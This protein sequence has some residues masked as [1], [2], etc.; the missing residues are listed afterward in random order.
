L[1][2]KKFDELS[3]KI[4][5]ANMDPGV[6]RVNLFPH[7]LIAL[8]KVPEK[9]KKLWFN[10]RA[11]FLERFGKCTIENQALM[12][13]FKKLEKESITQAWKR[14][15]KYTCNLEHGL[16]DYMLLYSFYSGLNQQS[17][18]L[19]DKESD[20][21]FLFNKPY[22]AFTMLDGMLVEENIYKSIK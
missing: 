12:L 21:R 6:L 22:D 20:I 10:L 2:V 13:D 17:K 16:R 14:F 18:H 19:L 3:D 9:E 8:A 1:H 11:S 4:K 7:S 5:P 15:K